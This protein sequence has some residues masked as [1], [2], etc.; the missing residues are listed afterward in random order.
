MTRLLA[1]TIVALGVAIVLTQ[2]PCDAQTGRRPEQLHK[3]V[4]GKTVVTGRK[5]T[6]T[7]AQHVKTR[8]LVRPPHAP[9]I[10]DPVQVESRI[11]R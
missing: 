7:K 9:L 4:K 8:K 6:H 5:S 3:Q 10:Y 11:K 1:N 2:V